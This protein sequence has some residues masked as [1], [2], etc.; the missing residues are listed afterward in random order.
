M[1]L[2]S[3]L[4][5]TH[6]LGPKT[7]LGR[8]TPTGPLPLSHDPPLSLDPLYLLAMAPSPSGGRSGQRRPRPLPWSSAPALPPPSSPIP[9]LDSP[10][11]YSKRARRGSLTLAILARVTDAVPRLPR[12]LLLCRGWCG[13]L[14][15]AA[16]VMGGARFFPGPP[17]V[18]TRALPRH[19]GVTA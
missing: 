16:M 19:P 12:L 4:N 14:L 18:T 9:Q 6:W 13:A 1:P 7:W 2:A 17:P 5:P 10:S 8:S 11:V 15:R 3:G